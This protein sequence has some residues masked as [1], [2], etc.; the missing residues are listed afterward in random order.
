[1]VEPRRDGQT[2]DG[3]AALV[4]AVEK[5]AESLREELLT[6]GERGDVLQD[7]VARVDR[8]LRALT[9]PKSET[10]RKRGNHWSPE[11]KARQ[12]E[13]VRER[14]RQREAAAA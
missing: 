8:A 7:K 9:A 2:P 14:R 11:A 12:S 10:G 3:F 4:A 1:M 5:T 6:V 13:R